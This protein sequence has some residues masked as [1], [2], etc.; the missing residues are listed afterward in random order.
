MEMQ[1]ANTVTTWKKRIT[2][3]GVV[4]MQYNTGLK[5]TAKA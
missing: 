1:V 5:D 4:R 3:R 2:V